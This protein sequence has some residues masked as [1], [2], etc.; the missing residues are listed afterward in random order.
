[1]YE[2]NMNNNVFRLCFI[3]SSQVLSL[4]NIEEGQ[5]YGCDHKP[6]FEGITKN[7]MKSLYDAVISCSIY[8][9]Y[10]FILEE[11]FGSKD[12]ET[13]QFTG[14]YGSLYRNESDISLVALDDPFYDY[15]RVNPHQIMMEYPLTIIQAY[16]A[17]DTFLKVDIF[18]EGIHSFP[19]N[20]WM[21]ILMTV[22]YFAFLFFNIDY[23]IEKTKNQRRNRKSFLQIFNEKFKSLFKYIYYCF[24]HLL[25]SNFMEFNHFIQ[26]FLGLLLIIF[27]FLITNYF[28]NLMAT[29]LVVVPRPLIHESYSDLIERNIIPLF[30]RH[31][32]EYLYFKNAVNSSDMKILWEKSVIKVGNISGLFLPEKYDPGLISWTNKMHEVVIIMN[33]R[34]ADAAKIGICHLIYFKKSL[35]PEDSNEYQSLSK[36]H[37]WDV[38]DPSAKMISKTISFRQTIE[39][40]PV[41][42]NTMTRMRYLFESDLA[43]YL[44]H[45]MLEEDLVINE[46]PLMSTF[47]QISSCKS[48]TLVMSVPEHKAVMLSNLVF[49]IHTC[50]YLFIGSTIILFIEILIKKYVNK[51][52]KTM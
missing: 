28:I 38:P 26:N 13:G 27:G 1:M 36:L 34:S 18:K 25:N 50:S 3:K 22:F 12:E 15:D 4:K 21:L 51:N 44:L 48:N 16:N 32:N 45:H 47:E 2:M 19:F 20:I 43:D 9:N 39:R 24:M 52:M 11:D 14:C 42:L 49:L 6:E 17:S 33:R 30:P 37:V 5:V 46:L 7:I 31:F 41:V 35:C 8:F 23:F 10:T 40:S 29:E